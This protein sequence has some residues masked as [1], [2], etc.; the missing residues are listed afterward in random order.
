MEHNTAITTARLTARDWTAGDVDAAFAVYGPDEVARWFGPQPRRPVRSLAHIHE[1]LDRRITR[2]LD[3]PDYGLW[4][5]R[6]SSYRPGCWRTT[7]TA[8]CA[9]APV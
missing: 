2:S 9:G 8:L 1:I 5:S 3:Q 6:A 7:R 4:G